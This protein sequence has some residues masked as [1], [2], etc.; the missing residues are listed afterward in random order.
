MAAELHLVALEVGQSVFFFHYFRGRKNKM[1]HIYKF[2]SLTN[3]CTA[4]FYNLN[5]LLPKLFY[6]RWMVEDHLA[7][8]TL[9]D[10]ERTGSSDAVDTHLLPYNVCTFE[11]CISVSW[12]SGSF[13]CCRNFHNSSVKPYVSLLWKV[14]CS[15]SFIDHHFDYTLVPL[16]SFI[17]IRL[18]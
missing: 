16:F 2:Q 3:I 5:G 14:D 7:V 18:T 11:F 9:L 6:Q 13:S 4:P 17:S 15:N 12:Y 8:S 10:R 1:L